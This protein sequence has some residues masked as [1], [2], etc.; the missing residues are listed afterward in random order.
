[1]VKVPRQYWRGTLIISCP[2][3]TRD[4]VDHG[5]M[6][7]QS[8]SCEEA[9]TRTSCEPVTFRANKNTW[10]LNLW[11]FEMFWMIF[12]VNRPSRNLHLP[13]SLC[14]CVFNF[15]RIMLNSS[16]AR[17][18]TTPLICDFWSHFCLLKRR[19]AGPLRV[20][21][22]SASAFHIWGSKAWV[23]PDLPHFIILITG[24]G[25]R[26]FSLSL[27]SWR[28]VRAGLLSSAATQGFY[29]WL[30]P[31]LLAAPLQEQL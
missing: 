18:S 29:N 12:P 16:S 25:P 31:T 24:S 21:E 5:V 9:L 4:H 30:V 2:T 19:L 26:F 3:G 6:S 17:S 8:D 22:F 13:L 14:P 1:M 7:G 20:T 28:Y 10:P 23:D 27:R 15:S 11:S